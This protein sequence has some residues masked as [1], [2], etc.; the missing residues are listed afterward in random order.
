MQ[1]ICIELPDNFTK[2]QCLKVEQY[3]YAQ[4]EN[5]IRD[6]LVIPKEETDRI[7]AELASVAVARSKSSVEA[8]EV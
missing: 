5:I 1:Q 6:S 3:A 2:E 4:V 7:E 8:K